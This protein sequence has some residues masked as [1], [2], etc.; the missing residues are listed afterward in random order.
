VGNSKKLLPGFGV[1]TLCCR[2]TR[3]TNKKPGCL[4]LVQLG[5]RSF[6]SELSEAPAG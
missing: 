6:L 4:N 3:P 5:Q 1:L 2:D